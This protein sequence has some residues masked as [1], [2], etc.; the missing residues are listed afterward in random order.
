MS[1]NKE[2]NLFV[3][4]LCVIVL[5]AVVFVWLNVSNA[6]IGY[7]PP[8]RPACPNPN[9][10]DMYVNAGKSVV[11]K[12]QIYEA[13]SNRIPLSM[14]DTSSFNKKQSGNGKTSQLPAGV[15]AAGTLNRLYNIKEK[16]ALLTANAKALRL[17]K[18]GLKQKY[19]LPFQYNDQTYPKYSDMRTLARLVSFQSAV[20]TDKGEF[21]NAINNSID[22]LQFG[23]DTAN[24]GNMICGLVSIAIQAIVRKDA[25]DIADKLSLVESKEAIKKLE[26]INSRLYP[27]K[28]IMKEEKNYSLTMLYEYLETKKWRKN[29]VDIIDMIS[30][31]SAGAQK[32]Q[33][34][35]N[36]IGVFGASRR[37][38][39]Y[40]T[41]YDY[42]Q[43]IYASGLSYPELLKYDIVYSNQLSEIILP[44]MNKARFK[45]ENNRCLNE[46][47]LLQLALH[48]YKL[49]HKTYPA[50]LSDLVPGYIKKL[51]TDPFT[52]N[53]LYKYAL[54][55]NGYL[56]YSIGPDLKDDGGKAVFQKNTGRRYVS[57]DDKGDIVAGFNR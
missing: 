10:Y 25:W 20:Y 19:M 7:K 52:K 54:K 43:L 4:I 48:A 1:R 57:S 49:E 14:A 6:P 32:L 16:Q 22:G 28:S 50:R 29:Y 55:P 42:D 17:F 24:G 51:P 13:T 53:N 40:N 11:C 37:M 26:T 34:L 15:P 27:F 9:A 36:H 31:Q 35:K 46:L 33:S 45:S 21:G 3:G 30:D 2:I 23:N 18:Q 8:V 56:L 47:L 5:I 39:F 12:D 44:V 38:L 41:A